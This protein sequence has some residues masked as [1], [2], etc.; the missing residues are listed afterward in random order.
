MS[1]QLV[2]FLARD[3]RTLLK[4]MQKVWYGSPLLKCSCRTDGAELSKEKLEPV[5][6]RN[7]TAVLIR[8]MQ[9]LCA[10]GLKSIYTRNQKLSI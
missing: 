9:N 7:G 10:G 6:S 4:L 3:L 2:E 8:S 1:S 5:T